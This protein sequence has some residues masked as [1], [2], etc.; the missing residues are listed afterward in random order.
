MYRWALY[1]REPLTTWCSGSV[2][3]LGDAA[4]PMLPFM[5]QG[6]C[7]AIEDAAVLLRCL[8]GAGPDQG[9]VTRALT[10][11]ESTRAERATRIQSG[12]YFNRIVFHYPDGEE[13]VARDAMFASDG[14]STATDW[15]YG[16]DPLTAPLATHS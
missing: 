13:Q 8:E 5:A 7:Q 3:L 16:Y 1:D 10:T 14:W 4:H 9:S 6:A 15:V 12:S 2:A 11:Y